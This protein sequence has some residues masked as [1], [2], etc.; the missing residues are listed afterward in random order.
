MKKV[1]EMISK[2]EELFLSYSIILMAAILICGVFARAVLNSSLTFTEEV[3]QMLNIIVTFFGIG[4]CARQARHISMSV[5]YDLVNKKGKKVMMCIISLVT[6]LIMFYLTY[7]SVHYVASVLE[8]GRVTAAL[9]IP[10]WITYIPIPLG[11]LLGGIE[12]LRT[13]VANIKNKDEIFISS[14]YRHGENMEE[15]EVS[16]KGDVN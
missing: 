10:M 15:V 16:E 12:Y 7:L 2:I 14:I 6:S 5:V 9:R 3:G 8:L 1:D 11:F 13:F 4:Y